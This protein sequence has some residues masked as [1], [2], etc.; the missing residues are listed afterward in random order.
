[1]SGDG[2]ESVAMS[3]EGL[4]CQVCDKL[5]CGCRPG[6]CRG[7]MMP[8]DET[9]DTKRKY[10]NGGGEGCVKEGSARV[11]KQAA[12]ECYCGTALVPVNWVKSNRIGEE[13]LR[14]TTRHD[15]NR[16]LGTGAT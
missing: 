11:H 13:R 5:F 2:T 7:V 1:M 4:S 8:S 3:T 16:G 6:M 9:R 15:D 14:R 10:G 12:K